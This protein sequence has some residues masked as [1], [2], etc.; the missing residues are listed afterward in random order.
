MLLAGAA[1]LTAGTAT[2]GAAGGTGLAVATAGGAGRISVGAVATVETAGDGGATTAARGTITGAEGG[3]GGVAGGTEKAGETGLMPGTVPVVGLP[4]FCHKRSD[5]EA[6][7][8]SVNGPPSLLAK[9][10]INEPGRPYMIQV[11][12]S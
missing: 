11:F 9:P 3:V 1:G 6:I 2:L 12:Q 4:Y 5:S 7:C 8:S 10:G